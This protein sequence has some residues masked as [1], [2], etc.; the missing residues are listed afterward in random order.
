MADQTKTNLIR[1]GRVAGAFGVRGE[2]K[3]TAYTEEPK[4]LIAF[5][6][7]LREDGSPGLTLLSGRP[8]KDAVIGKA[9]Q[10]ATKEEADALRGLVLYVPRERLPEPADDEFYLTDLIGLAAVTPQGEALGK[11]KTVRDFGA[12]D[13]LEIQPPAGPSWW[14]AFTRET[15]PEIRLA[16]GEIVVVRP[17]ETSEK[18]A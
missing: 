6:D 7:L 18:D 9:A 5:R 11:V 14:I 3:V 16:A 17:E 4:T 15:A 13:V 10:I 2:V 12:G 1:V 8:H